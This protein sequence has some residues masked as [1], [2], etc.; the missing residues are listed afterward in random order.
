[1]KAIVYGENHLRPVDLCQVGRHTL[2]SSPYEY[3]L[4]CVSCS[5]PIIISDL[6]S[7]TV[8]VLNES[9]GFHISYLDLAPLPLKQFDAAQSEKIPLTINAAMGSIFLV[10]GT[11]QE[12]SSRS[13][14]IDIVS[15]DDMYRV[16][17][18][19]GHEIWVNGNAHPGYCLKKIRI[20]ENNKT[21]L[22]YHRAK[23]ETNLLFEGQ[24]LLHYKKDAAVANDK[25]TDDH[26]AEV[27]IGAVTAIDIVPNTIHRIESLTDILLYEVSTP[28]L[29]DV[30]R[31]QDDTKRKDGR[32][33]SEHRRNG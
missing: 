5:E 1:M 17:K 26:I 22:Q 21:S 18:P 10:A 20:N 30:V 11:K 31:L 23:Q 13:P 8:F 29:D 28:H 14:S 3:Y 24:A 9:L 16:N 6:G 32:V 2:A 12:Q 25:V 7:F 33:E 15:E 4:Y 27:E 19:W